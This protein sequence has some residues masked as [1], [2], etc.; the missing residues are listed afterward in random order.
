MIRGRT[1]GKSQRWQEGR[2][3]DVRVSFRSTGYLSSSCTHRTTVVRHQPPSTIQEI[4]EGLTTN[5]SD[6]GLGR[7][8]RG[9]ESED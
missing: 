4:R 6:T 1:V 5:S 8:R 7:E 9:D 2:E 3:G